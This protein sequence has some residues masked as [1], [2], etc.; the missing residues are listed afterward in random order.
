MLYVYNIVIVQ[1]DDGDVKIL[2]GETTG[3]LEVCSYKR[4]ATA[5]VGGW[6]H[7]DASVVCRQLGYS[8]GEI[9]LLCM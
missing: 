1:C 9:L 4:W 5:C 2:S 7:A 6:S 8:S 3:Q